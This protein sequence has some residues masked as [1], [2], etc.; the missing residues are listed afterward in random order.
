MCL[1]YRPLFENLASNSCTKFGGSYVRTEATGFGLIYF[2][3]SVCEA[4]NTE[5]KNKRVVVSGAGNVA[6]HAAQKAIQKGAC[7]VTLS[8]S[9]GLLFCDEGFSE[10]DITWAIKQHTTSDNILVD[11]EKR[12][13][14]F[15]LI[16]MAWRGMLQRKKVAFFATGDMSQR[17]MMRRFIARAAKRPFKADTI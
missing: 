10:A 8:N 17:Q 11:L 9:R 2:T 16:D 1:K 5:L 12:G 14:T 7:V 6:L 3:E 13:K 15:W 4:N